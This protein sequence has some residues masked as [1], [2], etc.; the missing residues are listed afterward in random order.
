MYTGTI[1]EWKPHKAGEPTGASEIIG[2]KTYNPESTEEYEK[3][4]EYYAK[5]AE[6][7]KIQWRNP[8]QHMFEQEE[9]RYVSAPMFS[10]RS[11]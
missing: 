3:E 4:R 10:Y 11:P 2:H 1:F 9:E 6:E 5:L 8:L 7:R